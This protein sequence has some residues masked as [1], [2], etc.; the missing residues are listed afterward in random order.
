MAPKDVD[1]E[2]D[3]ILN[4]ANRLKQEKLIHEQQTQ[5]YNQNIQ[6]FDKRI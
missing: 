4:T 2:E 6:N 5:L 3:D 1:Q